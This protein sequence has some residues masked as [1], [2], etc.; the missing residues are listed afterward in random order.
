L[1]TGDGIGSYVSR[2][3][4]VEEKCTRQEWECLCALAAPAKCMVADDHCSPSR[5][6]YSSA[7]IPYSNL[8]HFKYQKIGSVP[9]GW[10]R[11]A[12]SVIQRTLLLLAIPV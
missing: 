3:I 8:T 7:I 9:R 5:Q 11:H 4:S 10:Q 2:L 6:K 12:G 1:A